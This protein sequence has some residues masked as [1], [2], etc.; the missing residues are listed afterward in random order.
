MIRLP[1]HAIDTAIEGILVLAT[2]GCDSQGR[3]IRW[4]P[5]PAQVEKQLL[6]MMTALTPTSQPDIVVPSDVHHVGMEQLPRQI[7]TDLPEP[8]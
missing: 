5:D 7:A 1:R 2:Q 3:V 4:R 6:A 8:K